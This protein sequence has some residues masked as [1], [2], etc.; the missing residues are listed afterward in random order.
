M[1]G[2]PWRCDV[3]DISLDYA[4]VLTPNIGDAG[5]DPSRLE[6]DLADRFRAAHATAE[7][8]RAEGTVG[9]FD[10]PYARKIA[11]EVQEVADSCRHW[12]KD[13][14]VVGM[15]GSALG[16][17]A[18]ADAL[19]GADWNV[20]SDDDRESFPRLHVVDNV[21]PDTLARLLARLDLRRTL[22]NIVSKSGAT[23]ETMAQYLVVRGQLVRTVE[24]DEVKGH[25]LF[26]TDP[27]VGALRRIA[28]VEGISA[29]SIP[30]NVGGRFSVLS[31]AGLLPAAMC[32][33]DLSALLAGGADM[34]ARCRGPLLL[35]NPAGLF[36][37]VLHEADQQRGARTHVLIPYADR[38][39]AFALW[40]QQLWAESLGKQLAGGGGAV[41]P[42]P[43][44]ARG[45][46]DQHSLLQ[47]FMEGPPDKVVVF[48]AV[49]RDPEEVEI[50]AL[51]ADLSELAYLGGRTLAELLEAEQLA[52]AEALRLD[53][54]PNMTIEVSRIDERTLGGLFLFFQAATVY[55]AA[56]YGVDPMGQPGVEL[57][58]R[59]T[60]GLLGREG[61]ERPELPRAA[62]G[63]DSDRW[64]V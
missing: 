28:E 48:V 33:V 23:A 19:L 1:T 2:S 21:D 57:G 35:Q 39:W 54:R 45:A 55:A 52:T 17:R 51:H 46:S 14:V 8:W 12:V 60:H 36:A 47:L 41:G 3:R 62:D 7:R 53:S 56:L 13:L 49:G 15:G 44:P 25:L 16:T 10:L 4:N 5:L 58:K 37:T 32:G 43:L 40:F 11:R 34:G 27:Q 59:L 24:E 63:N 42:T 31:P 22:F 30:K 9:F 6:G 29:L 50:P 61:Y 64:R 38:L 18:L 26:T 20:R